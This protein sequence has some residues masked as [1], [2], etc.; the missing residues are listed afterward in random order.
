ME[1]LEAQ[2]KIIR[3]TI[4]VIV[5]FIAA[6]SQQEPPRAKFQPWGYPY[7][8]CKGYLGQEQGIMHVHQ[9]LKMLGLRSETYIYKGVKFW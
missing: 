7:G 1:A 3:Y 8:L 5:F 6:C 2:M 4:L 9:Q